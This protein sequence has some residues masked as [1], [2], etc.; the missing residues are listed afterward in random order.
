M[1]E[2]QSKRQQLRQR[3]NAENE[4]VTDE[5]LLEAERLSLIH[6]TEISIITNNTTAL[7]RAASTDVDPSP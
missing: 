6:M 7:N 4:A 1:A 2:T 5:D 3:F